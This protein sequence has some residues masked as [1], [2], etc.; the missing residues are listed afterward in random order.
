MLDCF[1]TIFTLCF[2]V[3]AHLHSRVCTFGRMMLSKY[4]AESI[5]EGQWGRNVLQSVVIDSATHLL[6]INLPDIGNVA[7]SLN[8][9]IV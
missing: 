8:D 9:I 1:D 2:V 4:I 6:K 3:D 5:I 7:M